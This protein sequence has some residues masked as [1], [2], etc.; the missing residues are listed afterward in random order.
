MQSRA[1]LAQHAL[2]SANGEVYMDRD[3]HPDVLQQHLAFIG[4]RLQQRLIDH[5][6]RIFLGAQLCHRLAQRGCHLRAFGSGF[7]NRLG[8]ILGSRRRSDK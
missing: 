2:H 1:Y 7:P 5:H 8:A 6:R 3:R 4:L